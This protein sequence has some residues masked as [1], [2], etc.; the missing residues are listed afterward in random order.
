M[1]KIQENIFYLPVLNVLYLYVMYLNVL[2]MNI[3]YL[4]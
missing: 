4:K 1:K 2:Y 3:L